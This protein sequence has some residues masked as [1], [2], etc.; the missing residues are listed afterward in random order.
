MAYYQSQGV[1]TFPIIRRND[2]INRKARLITEENIVS[3]SNH[4]SGNQ[5]YILE[6]LNVSQNGLQITSGVCIINGYYFKIEN[7]I[8][9]NKN[10]Q[11]ETDN[12]LYFQ[13]RLSSTNQ[14]STTMQ[15]KELIPFETTSISDY[16]DYENEFIGLNIKFSSNII[17][18]TEEIFNLL[19]AKKNN[20][21]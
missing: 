21:T 8:T 12:Y 10:E 16:L 17:E 3:V 1:E 7:T 11:T 13:I 9:I 6:G 5:S 18:N 19:I 20:G 14:T 2:E 4:I 15:F